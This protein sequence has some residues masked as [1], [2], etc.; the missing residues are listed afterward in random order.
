M[1]AVKRQVSGG[2]QAGLKQRA[3]A[4]E[5][6]NPREQF[7]HK[8]WS[9]QHIVSSGVKRKDPVARREMG[10]DYEDGDGD[11]VFTQRS[12]QPG[13]RF[14]NIFAAAAGK[15]DEYIIDTLR[16]YDRIDLWICD[17]II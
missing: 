8:K 5:R 12:Q 11:A 4:A 7:A 3:S 13:E 6:T 9:G 10:R 17:M 2:E 14:N 15:Q 16:D 1:P